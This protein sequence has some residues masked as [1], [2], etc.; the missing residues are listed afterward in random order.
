MNNSLSL[1]Q[2]IYSKLEQVLQPE[3]IEIINQSS[4]HAHHPGNPFSH[5]SA[6]T[7]FFIR[8]FSHA[9]E[10][11]TLL[12]RHQMV[13]KILHEELTKTSLHALSLDLQTPEP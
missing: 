2:Q 4:S 6:E 1:Q 7:H 11:K 12:Q 13:Y 5:S 10:G 9:F 8:I 3:K